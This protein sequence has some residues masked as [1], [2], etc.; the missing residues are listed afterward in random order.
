MLSDTSTQCFPFR[1]K[2]LRGR[3]HETAKFRVC[4]FFRLPYCDIAARKEEK[5]KPLAEKKYKMKKNKC[6]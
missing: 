3:Q 5:R 4:A 1:S 2:M 6:V